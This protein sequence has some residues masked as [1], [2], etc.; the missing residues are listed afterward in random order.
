MSL[1]QVSLTESWLNSHTASASKDDQPRLLFLVLLQ[2]QTVFAI[3]EQCFAKNSLWKTWHVCFRTLPSNASWRHCLLLS[4]RH[5]DR[6]M[7]KPSDVTLRPTAHGAQC[8][9]ANWLVQ[10]DG[11][12]DPTKFFIAIPSMLGDGLSLSPSSTTSL[13]PRDNQCRFSADLMTA[14]VHLGGCFFTKITGHSIG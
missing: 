6:S 8:A 12:L 7:T 3:T 11:I 10:P 5:V 14:A 2:H 13:C 4:A 1:S 9:K